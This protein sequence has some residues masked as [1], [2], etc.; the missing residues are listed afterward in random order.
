MAEID[1]KAGNADTA[2]VIEI[3]DR[4][5][6]FETAYQSLVEQAANEMY[7]AQGKPSENATVRVFKFDIK[8]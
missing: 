6:R 1:Y 5:S 2:T 3:L 8:E 4:I 7:Q